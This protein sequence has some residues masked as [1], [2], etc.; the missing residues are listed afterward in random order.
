MAAKLAYD[1]DTMVGK[2]HRLWSYADSHTINGQLKRLS[3]AAL[4][5]LM[6][7]PGLY[8]ALAE[9]NWARE[10]NSEVILVDYVRHNGATAKR[11]ILTARRTAR[12]RDSQASRQR[13]TSDACDAS[14][15]SGI[16]EEK[17][18]KEE[19]RKKKEE[20]PLTP[21][22]GGN[23]ATPRKTRFDP[24]A[25]GHTR[26]CEH[27]MDNTEM[28]SLWSDWCAE[29]SSQKKPLSERAAAIQIR[30]L[31]EWGEEAA[32]ESIRASIANSW[33]G[34]FLPKDVPVKQIVPKLPTVAEI[35]RARGEIE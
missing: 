21:L 17:E 14:R 33:R 31:V 10:K 2:L 18:E 3:P 15:A 30:K 25:F 7:A 4:D 5:A 1:R 20:T 19:K 28:L 34:L 12:W 11:R 22:S 32:M 16:K 29:R 27:R 35:R 8:L 23:E 6:D 24:V 13:H 26:L 9:V